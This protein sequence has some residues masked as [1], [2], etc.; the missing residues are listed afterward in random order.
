[1]KD[2]RFKFI[3][4]DWKQVRY[5]TIWN[6]KRYLY[7]WDNLND[8]E[9]F[10]IVAKFRLTGEERDFLLNDDYNYI[11][12]KKEKKWYKD[13]FKKTCFWLYLNVNYFEYILN[14]RWF[15]QKDIAESM[16]ISQETISRWKQWRTVSARFVDILARTLRAEKELL[17]TN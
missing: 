9:I 11:F 15:K 14:L 1:M 8:D 3:G 12:S 13:R 17:F 16:W 5:N 10:E 7:E 6:L 4:I 2:E